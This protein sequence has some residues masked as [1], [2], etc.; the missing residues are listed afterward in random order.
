[1]NRAAIRQVEDSSVAFAYQ[2]KTI[3]K[4]IE[5]KAMLKIK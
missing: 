1:M 3:D 2:W 4:T 5:I